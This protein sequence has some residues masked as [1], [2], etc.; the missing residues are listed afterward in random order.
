MTRTTEWTHKKLVR[1]IANWAKY[2]KRMTVVLAELST[3]NSET[4][5]VIGWIGGAASVVPDL[6]QCPRWGVVANDPRLDRQ[7]QSQYGQ[8][9]FPSNMRGL[10][11]TPCAAAGGAGSAAGV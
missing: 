8:V 7:V 6:D 2:T 9:G 11:D 10:M 3:H 5:D 1:C 4:P